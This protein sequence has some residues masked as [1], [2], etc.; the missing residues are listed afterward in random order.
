ML[1]ALFLSVVLLTSEK[2]RTSVTGLM[3]SASAAIFWVALTRFN[4]SLTAY[5]GYRDQTYFPSLI[6][7]IITV[8]L[9]ALGILVLD[10]AARYLPIY[11]PHEPAG[12]VL[13]KPAMG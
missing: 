8:S 5:A 7:I 1:I 4:V 2:L 9:V 13:R 6:E 10:L 12:A 11:E 3:C